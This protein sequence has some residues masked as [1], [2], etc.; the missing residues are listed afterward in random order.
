MR[1][2]AI[3]AI[4]YAVVTEYLDWHGRAEVIEQRFPKIWAV[5]G[6][7]YARIVLILFALGLLLVPREGSTPEAQPHVAPAGSTAAPDSHDNV[8]AAQS[9]PPPAQPEAKPPSQEP[10]VEPLPKARPPKASGPLL[11]QHAPLLSPIRKNTELANLTTHNADASSSGTSDGATS[12]SGDHT[13]TS[14]DNEGDK[15]AA[16]NSGTTSAASAD[17][18]TQTAQ[19]GHAASGNDKPKRVVVL[20]FDYATV[21]KNSEAIFGAN[22]D[23]GKGVADLVAANLEKSGKYIVVDRASVDKILAEQNFS[24]SD[25]ADPMLAAKIGKLLGADT[26]I[27]GS[28]TQF[29]NEAKNS[30]IGS[31]FG[32]LGGIGH[33]KS[34][35]VVGLNVRVI[36]LNTAEI[37]AVANGKGESSREGTSMLSNGGDRHGFGGGAVDFSS[38]DFQNTMIGEA[39]DAAVKQTSTELVA[40]ES[41]LRVSPVVVEGLVAALDGNTI[42]LNIGQKAGLQVGDELSVARVTREIRDPATGHT[43]DKVT[44]PVGVIKVTEVDESSASAS[45]VTGSDFKVGDRVK[46]EI[47]H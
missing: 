12:S 33:K 6:S 45:P 20:D 46:A 9:S 30:S 1:I 13:Q 44:T 28:V 43:I 24:A 7:R 42:V 14:F 18:Q 41:K 38:S 40:N 31:G 19:V 23:V 2:I 15:T 27:V 36:N 35:A 26:V 8:G 11:V 5:I 34:K 4:A 10:L 25:R 21:A 17:Q 37:E 39:V 3:I 29:G 16:H 22:V 47:H 32:A